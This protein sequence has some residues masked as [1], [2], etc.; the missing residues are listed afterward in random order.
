MLFGP[1]G[2]GKTELAKIICKEAGLEQ[3]EL[4]PRSEKREN[5]LNLWQTAATALRNNKSAVL[6]IDEA[7]DLFNESLSLSEKRS[8]KACINEALES[9]PCPTIWM[10]NS[11]QSMDPSMIRRFY[12]VVKVDNPP[13]KRMKVITEKYLGKYL[14]E[15]NIARVVNTSKLSPGIVSQVSEIAKSLTEYSQGISQD[16]LMKLIEEILQAQGFGSLAKK[17]SGS[18]ALYDPK[19]TNATVNLDNLVAGLEKAGSGRLLPLRSAG[20]R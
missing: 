13:K 14:S 5:R 11:I 16:R 18:S 9:T 12:F 17:E 4:L 10:T 1:P 15:E 3:F 2:T 6:T 19:L 8:N 7:D 20:H